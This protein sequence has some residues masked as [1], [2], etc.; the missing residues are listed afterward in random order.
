MLAADKKRFR[1]RA[2]TLKPV[3]MM[4]QSGLTK[5]VLSEIE[6]ALQYHE[7]IKIRVR[8]GD[9]KERKTLVQQICKDTQAELIQS[10]GQI[11]VL[12]RARPDKH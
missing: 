5:N 11:A 1:T 3:V 6:N 4:G 8:N 10:I 12:Y 2:H 9:P 7:L